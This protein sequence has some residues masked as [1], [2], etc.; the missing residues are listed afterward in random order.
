MIW[1]RPWSE[2][3]VRKMKHPKVW[4]HNSSA[5]QTANQKSITDDRVIL[6]DRL[7]ISYKKINLKRRLRVW[8]NYIVEEGLKEKRE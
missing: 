6:T 8:E 2:E 5:N 3:N 1:W 7:S 4:R